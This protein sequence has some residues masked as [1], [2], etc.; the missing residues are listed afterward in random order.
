MLQVRGFGEGVLKETHLSRSVS[1][2]RFLV[3]MERYN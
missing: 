1:M 2:M 3:T